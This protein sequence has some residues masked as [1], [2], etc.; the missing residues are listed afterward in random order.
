MP[1]KC[2]KR[3]GHDSVRRRSNRRARPRGDAGPLAFGGALD[4][5]HCP[6]GP[7]AGGRTFPAACQEHRLTPTVAQPASFRNVV[8]L[9]IGVSRFSGGKAA[10]RR[11]LACIGFED[12]QQL[13]YLHK[14]VN[15][16]LQVQQ[17]HLAASA[18][19]GCIAAD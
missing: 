2:E 3:T 16:L 14:I 18:G 19:R 15:T 4:R 17:F 11:L 12:G 13:R 10:E 9:R 8:R 6:C 5:G 1:A 7:R